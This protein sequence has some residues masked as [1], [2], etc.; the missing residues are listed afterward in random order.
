MKMSFEQYIL[1]P[2]GK[3]NAVL[4]ATT[5]ELL[6]KNYTYRFDNLMLRENGKVEYHLYKDTKLNNVYWAHIKIPSEVVKNFY[7]DTIIQFMMDK[8]TPSGGEDLFKYNARFYSNDPAFVFTYMHVFLKNDLF[9][10]ELS[11]KMSKEAIR[12]QPKEKNPSNSMG[13]VKSLYFAYLIM[14][15]R[16][17]NK[18]NKFE[19]ECT[20]LNV[21]ALVTAV[22]HADLKIKKRQEEGSKLSS[23]KKITVDQSTLNKISKHIKS[24]TDTSRLQ[25]TTSK[26]VNTLKKKTGEVSSSKKV[27]FVKKK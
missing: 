17:L 21:K 25:V 3:D 12:K 19:A 6:R 27:G 20:P 8:N 18:K 13:Y 26:R 22:E 14:Q 24:D 16:K 9:I 1:N 7:Y 15:N 4:N 11:S 10:K 5:R 2:M 23:K